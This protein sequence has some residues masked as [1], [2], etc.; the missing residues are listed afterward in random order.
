[1]EPLQPLITISQLKELYKSDEKS[2][3]EEIK[4]KLKI[5]IDDENT[6]FNDFVHAVDHDYDSQE[7]VDCLLFYT[8]ERVCR[9]VKEG[10]KC[11]VC[12]R[13]FLST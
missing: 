13:A 5:V 10:V 12:L 6:D 8:T 2:A 4:E 7:V 9:F 3:I 11:S 1:M